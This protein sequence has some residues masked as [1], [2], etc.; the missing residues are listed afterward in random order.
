M[1]LLRNAFI[2]RLVN[3]VNNVR[4]GLLVVQNSKLNDIKN[5]NDITAVI[6][7]FYEKVH[8]DTEMAPIFKMSKEKWEIHL[9]R[10][11]NFWENWL[12]QTGNYHGGLM[13]VHIEKHQDHPLTTELFEKWLSYWFITVDELFEGEKAEFMKSKALEIGQ[14]MNQRLNARK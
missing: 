3:I 13:W 7:S 14:M 4:Q 10:T 6:K 2:N 1:R 9:H 5:R 12:F 11:E 8:N